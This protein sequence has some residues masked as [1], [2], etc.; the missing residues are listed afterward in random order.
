MEQ[1]PQDTNDIPGIEYTAKVIGPAYDLWFRIIYKLMLIY[2]I[3]YDWLEYMNS[4]HRI[5]VI[6][7]YN[8]NN[9]IQILEY[10]TNVDLKSWY[11]VVLWLYIILLLLLLCVA[12]AL[13]QERSPRRGARRAGEPTPQQ[14]INTLATI[15]YHPERKTFG[16]NNN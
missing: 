16:P 12:A 14:S 1:P 13:R 2:N 9:V 7:Q 11:T 8:V 3:N 10:L 5:N 4:R 6:D 15:R